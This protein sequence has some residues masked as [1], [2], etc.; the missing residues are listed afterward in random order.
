MRPVNREAGKARKVRRDNDSTEESQSTES[1]MESSKSKAAMKSKQ[2]AKEK[3]VH[4]APNST[5]YRSTAST[6]PSFRSSGKRAAFQD[7][8]LRER[9]IGMQGRHR[10]RELDL[11]GNHP[12]LGK[13]QKAQR[14][15]D[16]ENAPATLDPVKLVEQAKAAGSHLD[17][18]VKVKK[19]AQVLANVLS[20]N[21]QIKSL[22]LKG[23]FGG[24]TGHFYDLSGIS[25]RLYIKRDRHSRDQT[26]A[27]MEEPEVPDHKSFRSIL[28]ACKNIRSL[29]LT[30]CGLATAN[31]V[32]LTDFLRVQ[33]LLT[34]LELGAGTRLSDADAKILGSSFT[35]PKSSIRELAIDG[36]FT[37]S[38]PTLMESVK[39]HGKFT[40][41]KLERIC[42]QTISL[43]TWNMEE[44]LGLCASNP[45]LKYLSMAGTASFKMSAINDV[46]YRNIRERFFG[47]DT[48]R[49]QD[50]TL[51]L[52]H[53][54]RVL[55]LSNC[56]L[57]QAEMAR[58]ANCVARNSALLEIRFEGNPVSDADRA[59][60][61]SV[62]ARNREALERRASAALDLL[63]SHAAKQPDVWPP[64]LIGVLIENTPPEVLLD[65]AAVIVPGAGS[66]DN[67]LGSMPVDQKGRVSIPGGSSSSA[68]LRRQ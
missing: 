51:E 41:I 61:V 67:G 56:D 63:I 21:P 34:R 44:I 62:M 58:L 6:D 46:V 52:H 48:Y 31:W 18:Q 32:A 17:V 24:L 9:E 5:T 50:V 42:P 30:G 4:I 55:D 53:S 57:D 12:E 16:R 47:D 64:E 45:M 35:S 43:E 7:K 37:D 39:Q 28:D 66:S 60:L 3:E 10:R 11:K 26:D 15:K 13:L 19:D 27:G 25:H 36:L 59:T 2:Q 20:A 65:L 23:N 33:P 8:A 1:S 54:L 49:K 68:S 40:V 38:L 22:K 14:R 29:N